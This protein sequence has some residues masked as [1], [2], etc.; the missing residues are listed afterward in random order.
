MRNANKEIGY[1]SHGALSFL[2]ALRKTTITS[3]EADFTP[4]Q[5]HSRPLGNVVYII[6]SLF[7]RPEVMRAMEQAI[8]N[9][10]EA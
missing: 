1:E 9:Q 5:I 8:E 3:P 7:T 6:T 10:L 4:L 2:N